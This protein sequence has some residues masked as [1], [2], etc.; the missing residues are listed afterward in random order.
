MLSD[1]R[2]QIHSTMHMENCIKKLY[3]SAAVY[4]YAVPHREYSAAFHR[5]TVILQAV[6]YTRLQFR[7]VQ[8]IMEDELSAETKLME[9]SLNA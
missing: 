9:T 3:F 6:H 2:A 5:Q 7:P 1:N 8:I 4:A